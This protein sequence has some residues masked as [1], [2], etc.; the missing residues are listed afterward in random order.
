MTKILKAFLIGLLTL[1]VFAFATPVS[2]DKVG[3]VLQPLASSFSDQVKVPYLTATS[4]ATSTLPNLTATN[5]AVTGKFYGGAT[6]GTNGQVLQTTGAGVQ[7]VATSSL[8]LG[9][10]GTV[11][12]VD[13]TVPTGLSISGNPVTTSGTLALALTA[14]YVIPLSASTTNWESF[15]LTPSTRITAGTGIDWSGNTLNGVYTAGD[16]ITL[17]TEDFDCDTATSAVFGCLAAADWTIFNNKVSSSSI[18]TLAELETLQGGINIIQST[19]IDTVGEIETLVGSQNLLLETEIDASS[20]LLALMDD[21]TGTGLLTFATNPLFTG[22]RSSASS[23][24]A[25]LTVTTGTTT[26]A[27][28]T[29]L[30]STLGTFTN[31]VV[32]T[33]LTAVSATIT[34]LTA[35]NATSTNATS[36]NFYATNIS[37]PDDIFSF[38]FASTS[39]NFASGTVSYLPPRPYDYT[40][41]DI[42]CFV[43]GGTSKRVIIFGETLVCG[44]TTTADDGSIAIANVLAGSSTVSY[45]AS[46]TVGVVNHVLINVYGRKKYK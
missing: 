29:S 40:V 16:G 3:S 18:D 43:S 39:T 44:T 1:P 25:A 24:I 45:T 17:N 41:T 35:T 37:A 14:G 11:T 15:Y 2:W 21:E 38:S 10:S 4:T 20:E 13:M 42:D 23:T 33:L 5:F 30:F 19:E 32:N 7:W 28:S 46:T 27:T 9:G 26:N 6:P 8:G 34:N 12:S 31:S 36:T 22:L